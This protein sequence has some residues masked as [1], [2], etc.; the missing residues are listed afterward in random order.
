M[1]YIPN[2]FLRR[3]HMDSRGVS[4]IRRK[5]LFGTRSTSTVIGCSY[6]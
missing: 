3:L 1:I 6:D 5:S 2:S 4:T